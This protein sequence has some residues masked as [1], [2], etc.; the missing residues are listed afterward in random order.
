LVCC[1][2]FLTAVVQRF[3]LSFNMAGTSFKSWKS[4]LFRSGDLGV[5]RLGIT[6]ATLL[7]KLGEPDSVVPDHT[8]RYSTIFNYED[9]QFHFDTQDVLRIIYTPRTDEIPRHFTD[10]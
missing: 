5:I 1:L 6:K 4:Q 2:D 9:M 10:T 8:G 7:R 3:S